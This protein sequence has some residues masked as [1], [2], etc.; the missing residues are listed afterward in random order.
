M[1]ESFQQTHEESRAQFSK[2]AAAYVTSQGHAKGHDLDILRRRAGDLKGKKALDIATGGGH[3]ALALAGLGA[4]VTATDLTPEML[5]V[6]REFITGQGVSMDFVEAAAEALP[7]SDRSFDLVS[8]RI[9]PHHFADPVRFLQ[10]VWRVLKPGGQ[11]LLIDNISPEDESLARVVNHIEK[12]RDQSHVQAYTASWL[13]DKSSEQGFDLQYFERWRRNKKF[14]RWASRSGMTD[15][16]IAKLESWIRDLD[17]GAQLYLR[18]RFEGSELID[19]D[20]EAA[21]FDLHKPQI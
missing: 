2:T 7:F 17:S 9:A 21:L 5:A 3:T 6:A 19:L 8:C 13:I 11:F 16:G 1:S 12:E 14:R 15:E 20:H 4:E 18:S 10:E